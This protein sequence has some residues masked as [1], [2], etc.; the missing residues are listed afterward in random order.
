MELERTGMIMQCLVPVEPE[1]IKPGEHVSKLMALYSVKYEHGKYHKCKCRCVYR[2]NF[3]KFGVDFVEKSSLLPLL[4]SLRLFLALPPFPNEKVRRM[5][6][7][8]RSDHF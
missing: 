8:V 6:V 3:D 5:D 4:S 2:G 1:D 7:P